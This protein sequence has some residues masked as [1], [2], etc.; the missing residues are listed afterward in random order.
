MANVACVL[1]QYQGSKAGSNLSLG[2]Q[3]AAAGLASYGMV[4]HG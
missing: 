2:M 4:A 3:L 1:S